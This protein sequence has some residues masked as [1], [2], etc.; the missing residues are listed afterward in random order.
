MHCTGMCTGASS[1]S[2]R[3]GCGDGGRR[4]PAFPEALPPPGHHTRGWPLMSSK[5]GDREL[6]GKPPRWRERV[7]PCCILHASQKPKLCLLV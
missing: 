7:H 4:L 3:K 5:E 1:A 6:P 2:S